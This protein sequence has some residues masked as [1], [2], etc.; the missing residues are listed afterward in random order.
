[1]N[2]TSYVRITAALARVILTDDRDDVSICVADGT[3]I[4]NEKG[5]HSFQI[6]PSSVLS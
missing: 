1:M 6:T 4:Y 5:N 3:Y 2:C